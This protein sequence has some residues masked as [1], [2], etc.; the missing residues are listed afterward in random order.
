MGGGA[1]SINPEPATYYAKMPPNSSPG[2][3]INAD[4]N[5]R[6]V[7]VR[8]PPGTS[9]GQLFKFKATDIITTP[10]A[11]PGQAYPP[12]NFGQ[13]PALHAYDNNPKPGMH[14]TTQSGGLAPVQPS[15][16]QMVQ[17]LNQP[18]SG[19]QMVQQLNQPLSGAQMVQQL[20]QPPSGAQMVQQIAAQQQMRQ[21]QQ[22]FAQPQHPSQ[23]TGA[24]LVQ[25][26]GYQQQQAQPH[27]QMMMMPANTPFPQQYFQQQPH[28]MIQPQQ[29]YMQQPQQQFMMQPQQQQY[30]Q[31]MHVQQ[32]PAQAQHEIPM[33]V[34]TPIQDGYHGGATIV[35]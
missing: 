2:D 27:Q 35:R 1:S 13:A 15:G 7:K 3:I 22:M 9:V 8:V 5:G 28:Y 21:P 16:A 31:Q 25:Q 11:P 34:A 18:P 26:F 29:Q 23:M 12:P 4:V 6:P 33:V 32:P 20:N 19:A 24:Q 17:Q 10:T 30:A 14:Y